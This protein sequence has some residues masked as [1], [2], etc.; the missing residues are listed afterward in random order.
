MVIANNLEAKALRYNM[1]HSNKNE[2]KT[3]R[4]NMK[5]NK[6]EDYLFVV[7]YNQRWIF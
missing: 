3:L 2:P 1:K 5:Q 4:Y 6:R 7:Q